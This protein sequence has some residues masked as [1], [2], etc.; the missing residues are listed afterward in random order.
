MILPLPGETG[1]SRI[2]LGAVLKPRLSRALITSSVSHGLKPWCSKVARAGEPGRAHMGKP[3]ALQ[4]RRWGREQGSWL[5]WSRNV[6]HLLH[7]GHSSSF[8][9]GVLGG[10]AAPEQ[11]GV[12][13]PLSAAADAKIV[14]GDACHPSQWIA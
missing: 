10:R 6:W 11:K 4:E 14:P 1:I 5:P 2:G 8:S 12:A 7:P 3:R 9:M 13:P